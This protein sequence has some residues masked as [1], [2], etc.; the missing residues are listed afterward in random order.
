MRDLSLPTYIDDAK[1]PT[2][3]TDD[4]RPLHLHDTSAHED[5]SGSLLNTN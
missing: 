2:H 1:P 5:I 4:G 3:N